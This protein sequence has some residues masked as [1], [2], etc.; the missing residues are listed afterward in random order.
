VPFLARPLAMVGIAYAVL[1]GWS[2]GVPGVHYPLDIL[3]GAGIAT[4]GGMVLL[5]LG[6]LLRGAGRAANGHTTAMQARA[7][8]VG[9]EPY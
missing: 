9:P 8:R 3:G 6:M 2:P 5:A 1:V 4:A 7:P